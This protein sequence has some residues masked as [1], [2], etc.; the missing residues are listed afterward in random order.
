MKNGHNETST[1]EH[2]EE[3]T[4]GHVGQN[5]STTRVTCCKRFSEIAGENPASYGRNLYDEMFDSNPELMITDDGRPS[6]SSNRRPITKENVKF[7]KSK[8]L[9]GF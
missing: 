1:N 2:N 6:A 7:I 3:S 5:R 8:Y 4:N 9:F